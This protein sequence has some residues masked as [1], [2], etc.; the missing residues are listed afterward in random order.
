MAAMKQPCSTVSEATE[1]RASMC[2]DWLNHFLIPK[3][4]TWLC[5]YIWLATQS[6]TGPCEWVPGQM[7]HIVHLDAWLCKSPPVFFCEDMK[8]TWLSHHECKQFIHTR[9]LSNTWM[10]QNTAHKRG[11][12]KLLILPTNNF[13]M[14][15]FV[16]RPPWSNDV[17]GALQASL[18]SMG[19]TA[20]N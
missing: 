11:A 8:W 1:I 17:F 4:W 15:G 9:K 2:W 5:L 13:F 18:S 14:K 3:H 10:M 19:L 16:Q 7:A 12:S 20:G 6:I